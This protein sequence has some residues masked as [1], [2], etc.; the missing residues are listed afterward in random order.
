MW[1][2]HVEFDVGVYGDGA[3]FQHL[4]VAPHRDLGGANISALILD[5]ESDDLRLPD[6]A[7]AWRL[8][9][10]NAAIDLVFVARDERMQWRRKSQCRRICR[11][12][13]H[14]AVGD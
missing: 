6:D 2:R 11:Y 8:R 3:L 7:K 1:D 4:A 9:E 14:A 13:V 12:V 10:Y 5:P